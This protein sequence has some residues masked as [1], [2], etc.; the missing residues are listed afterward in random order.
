MSMSTSPSIMSVA[1]AALSIGA[2]TPF[3]ARRLDGYRVN[4]SMPTASAKLLFGPQ[5][6]WAI[7]D[8]CVRSPSKPQRRTPSQPPLNP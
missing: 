7:S 8:E 4:Q 6:A 2:M 1:A 3:V 5:S